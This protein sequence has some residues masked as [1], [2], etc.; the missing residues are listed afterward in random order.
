MNIDIE[1]TVILGLINQRDYKRVMHIIRTP[2]GSIPL[3]R[4]FGLDYE[5]VDMPEESMKALFTTEL[6]R[7]VTKH[8]PGKA[9][10]EITFSNPDPE[11]ILPRVVL[12]DE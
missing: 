4:S 12:I 11:T 3:K 10:Y 1:N 9:I 6:N 5:F 8:L 2:K 7:Q